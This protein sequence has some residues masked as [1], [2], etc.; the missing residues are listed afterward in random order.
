MIPAEQWCD[1]VFEAPLMNRLGDAFK[2][3]DESCIF[4]RI[5]DSCLVAMEEWQGVT[6]EGRICM[7]QH[8]PK[9]MHLNCDLAHR[10][11]CRLYV[12]ETGTT[13]LPHPLI[14][15]AQLIQ[16]RASIRVPPRDLTQ[17]PRSQSCVGRPTNPNER[18]IWKRRP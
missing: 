4:R 16:V 2:L 17:G 8:D 1:A 11:R 7:L 18:C 9:F 13:I 12:R 10:L 14:L 6:V 15:E 5:T 3:T